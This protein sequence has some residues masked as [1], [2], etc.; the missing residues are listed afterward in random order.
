MDLPEKFN[1]SCPVGG[2]KLGL[3]SLIDLDLIEKAK[4]NS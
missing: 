2:K 3:L 1:M 4:K